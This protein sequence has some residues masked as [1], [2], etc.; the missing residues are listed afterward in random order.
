[1]VCGG[2]QN[3]A[4]FCENLIIIDKYIG[5]ITISLVYTVNTIYCEIT[6][7]YRTMMSKSR[8]ISESA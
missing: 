7:K 2:L 3:F 8:N 1:M 4:V 6:R 5:N